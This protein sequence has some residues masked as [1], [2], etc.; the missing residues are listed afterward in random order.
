MTR[1]QWV[2]I[3]NMLLFIMTGVFILIQFKL[4][5]YPGDCVRALYDKYDEFCKGWAD[6]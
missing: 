1:N 5:A 3:K 2:F 4:E 6:L